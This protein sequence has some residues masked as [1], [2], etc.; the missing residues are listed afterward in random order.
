MSQAGQGDIKYSSSGSWT[1]DNSEYGGH[2]M[3]L[4]INGDGNDVI[5]SQ[6]SKTTIL[7]IVTW[8]S[9]DRTDDNNVFVLQQQN[10]RQVLDTN[11]SNNDDNDVFI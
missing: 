2:E 10:P 1:V 8:M 11:N 7:V 3:D 5:L 4:Y 9:N 6:R